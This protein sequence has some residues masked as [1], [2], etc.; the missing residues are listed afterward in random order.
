MRERGKK[1]ESKYLMCAGVGAHVKLVTYAEHEYICSSGEIII[2]R[3]NS[4]RGFL[5]IFWESGLGREQK[6]SILPMGFT[7]EIFI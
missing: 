6:G 7:E 5:L 3:S 2:A 4:E 1:S